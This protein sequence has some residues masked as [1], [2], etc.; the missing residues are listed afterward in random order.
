MNKKNKIMKICLFLTCFSFVL[1]FSK[2]SYS[3]YVSG[4]EGVTDWSGAGAA[5][6]GAGLNRIIGMIQI[7][8]AG[9]AVIAVTLM[10]IKYLTA[11]PNEKV[12]VKKHLLP[13]LIGSI[14]V[15]ASARV[16]EIISGLAD[17]L[18]TG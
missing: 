7:A 13:L 2:Y 1:T 12:D 3:A 11:G 6:I 16:V 5:G 14:L 17:N 8:G 18:P 15:F 10:G 9:A 4:M